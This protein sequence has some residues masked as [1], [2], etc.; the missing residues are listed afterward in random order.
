MTTE[1]LADVLRSNDRLGLLFVE[2]VIDQNG[3]F[4]L[5]T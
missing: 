3:K 2:K 1:E 4:I 5:W